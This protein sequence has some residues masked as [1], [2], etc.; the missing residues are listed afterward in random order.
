M[1]FVQE[2]VCVRD[3]VC[4]RL[5]PTL[6]HV[7]AEH[8]LQIKQAM[9]ILMDDTKAIQE[10]AWTTSSEKNAAMAVL[11]FGGAIPVKTTVTVKAQAT[12]ALPGLRN[13]LTP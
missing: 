2:G 5:D 11:V 9:N 13:G 3:P 7:A 12:T 4:R 8:N 1:V 10:K 6:Q